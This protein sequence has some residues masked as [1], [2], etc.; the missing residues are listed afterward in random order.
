MRRSINQLLAFFL[1]GLLALSACSAIAEGSVEAAPPAAE[2]DAEQPAAAAADEEVIELL[3][4]IE[5]ESAKLTTLKTRVRYTRLQTLTGDEQR[6]FGDFYYAAG[7]DDKPTRFAVLFDRLIIDGRARPMKTWFI[8]DGNW[9]LE[10]DHDDKTAVR[11]ELVPKG[12]EQSDMLNMGEGQL[13][14]PLKLKADEVLKQYR[15]EKLADVPFGDQTLLHFE[16]TPLNAGKD[17]AALELW[18][19]SETLLLQ[20]VL[21]EEDGDEIEMLFPTPKLNP[22]IEEEVFKTK[23]PDQKEGW[24]VQEVPIGK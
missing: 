2:P 13:P 5:V 23:L 24:Q 12:A 11:R 21:T 7:D 17:T 3:E 9:L 20:K 8:F 15:V 14:I 1:I 19:D 18:F 16:L 22:E 10:R 4:R 6:R